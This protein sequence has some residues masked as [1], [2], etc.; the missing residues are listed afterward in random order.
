MNLSRRVFITL[1]A[2]TPVACGIPLSYEG[3]TP[4][5]QPNPLPSVRLPQ[6]GQEW[7]YV[8]RDVFNGKT[9]GVITERVVKVGSPI[10]I[11]RNSADGAQLPSEIQS[12]WGMVTADPQ[13]PRL[14][15]FNPALPLWPQELSSQWGK[16]FITHYTVAGYSDNKLSWQEYMGSQGWEKITVPAGTFIAVR[17]QTQIHYQ[18][19]DDNKVDCM[20]KET[21]WFAPEIGR[22]VAREA[23]G[24]YEIQGQMG[25]VINEGS[26]RWELTAYR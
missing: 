20:R 21:L 26:Y 23:S 14:M 1:A 16:Q 7:T 9:L 11:E 13:W 5:A 25:A 24:S 6:V 4:V 17:F 12:T 19:D 3:G 22:W 10:V 2:L 18:S 8:K 15:N